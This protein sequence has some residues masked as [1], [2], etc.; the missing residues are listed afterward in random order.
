[1]KGKEHLT[2]EGVQEIVSIKVFF[3]FFMEKTCGA[4]APLAA[5]R[6]S[7]AGHLGAV[8]NNGLPENLKVAKGGAGPL[9]NC[10]PIRTLKGGEAFPDTVP[11]L[12]P[13]V[14]SHKIFDPN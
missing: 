9:L 1:M 3:I 13:Q 14:I 12:R 6:A 5:R 8:L 7:G 4:P 10:A 2:L 11:S